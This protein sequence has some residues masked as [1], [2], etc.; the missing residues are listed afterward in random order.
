MLAITVHL[1]EDAELTIYELI[2]QYKHQDAQFKLRQRTSVED[3]EHL[4][5]G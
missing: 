3:L 4:Q 1:L 5:P 2:S